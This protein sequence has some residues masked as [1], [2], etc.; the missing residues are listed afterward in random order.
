MK[1]L[2]TIAVCLIAVILFG[3]LC[4]SCTADTSITQAENTETGT[5]K[6]VDSMGTLIEIPQPLERVIVLDH[7]GGEMVRALGAE[8][9][10]VGINKSMASDQD[11]WG[12]LSSLPSGG[13]FSEPNYEKI[14]ELNPQVVITCDLGVAET[15]EKLESSGIKVVRLNFYKPL[16]F[17]SDI[18]TLGLMLDK[19]QEA[20]DLIDFFELHYNTVQTRIK[21]ISAEERKTVYYEGG[22][23]STVAGVSGWNE[24]ITLAGGINIFAG[25]ATDSWGTL[26]VSPESILEKDPSAIW[27]SGPGS[28]IPPDASEMVN[29]YNTLTS[30]AG[31]DNLSAVKNNRLLIMD[32]WTAKGCGKL[33][34]I[35][36]MAKLLYPDQFQDMDPGEI[37]REWFEV[38]Q[39]VE[40]KSG[41]IYPEQ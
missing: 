3:N 5:I 16:T 34:S 24:M 20:Q 2:K 9:K 32:Y 7:Y 29:L 14:V 4:V 23:Y 27:R 6:I 25:G 28:Y 17:V 40:Y 37:T 8:D 30:R 10:I 19:D 36:Y 22:D 31:W 13:F 15:E 21:T 41:Y 12:E 39:N 1:K 11:Y 35:C 18:R 26:K 33:V 38:F